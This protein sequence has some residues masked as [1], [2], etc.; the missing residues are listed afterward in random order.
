MR[1]IRPDKLTL[2]ALEATLRGPATPVRQGLDAVP[3]VLRISPRTQVLDAPAPLR[4]QRAVAQSTRRAPRP[5]PARRA[6]TSV[7]ARLPTP[8]R[9]CR[10]RCPMLV[11]LPT[12]SRWWAGTAPAVQAPIV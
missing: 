6:L 10:A 7:D 2:A 3:A 4:A 11:K 5:T 12:D 1:A 8:V 9:R